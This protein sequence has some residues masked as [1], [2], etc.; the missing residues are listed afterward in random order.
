MV[1]A[2]LAV[3]T[4]IRFTIIEDPDDPQESFSGKG[5]I[6]S[7]HTISEE[8]WEYYGKYCYHVLVRDID[9]EEP[10]DLIDETIPVYQK[11]ITKVV[12]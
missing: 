1:H 8:Y 5:K 11:Q 9:T 7:A 10:S 4:I 12:Q 6:L 3:G 2:K